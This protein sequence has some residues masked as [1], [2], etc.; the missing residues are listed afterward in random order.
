MQSI[1]QFI[2]K[3]LG[4]KFKYSKVYPEA[5]SNKIKSA[6]DLLVNAGLI[7]MILCS[8]GEL[9]LGA[10]VS[11]IK[12]KAIFL[13]IGLA[14]SI[15]D[16]DYQ[17]LLSERFWTNISGGLT[18]QFVGQE[19]LSYSHPQKLAQLYYWERA[20]QQSSAEIDYLINLFSKVWPVEVKSGKTGRLKSL[21]MFREKFSLPFGIRFSTKK[22]ELENDVLSVPL[23]AVGEL[24]RLIGLGEKL[25][26]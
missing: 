11:E 21:H 16:Y 18:E 17:D 12:F 23:Y 8:S 3:N 6:F 7:N 2:P 13:D 25:E 19:L 1:I 20:S 22:L 24:E 9:P 26:L 4:K 14:L 5:K 15:Y 10:I